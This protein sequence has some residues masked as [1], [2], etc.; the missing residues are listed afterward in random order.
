[1]I[2]NHCRVADMRG[3]FNPNMTNRM[4]PVCRNAH[5]KPGLGGATALD[6]AAR[7]SEEK[8]TTAKLYTIKAYNFLI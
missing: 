2:L 3:F 7:Y 8:I 6:A 4:G 5:R 1:M